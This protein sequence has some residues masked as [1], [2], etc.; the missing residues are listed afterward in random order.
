M[1]AMASWILGSIAVGYL[2]GAAGWFRSAR[3]AWE[4]ARGLMHQGRPADQ[5]RTLA[6][7]DALGSLLFFGLAVVSAAEAVEGRLSAADPFLVLGV[8][9]MAV[10]LRLAKRFQRLS[11]QVAD[12][13]DRAQRGADGTAQSSDLAELLGRRLSAVQASKIPGVAV[14][15]VYDP[16]EGVLGGDF[17][18]VSAVGCR[19]DIVVGDVTGHGFD[20]ALDAMRLKD[21]LLGL[22]DA[23][24]A[25]VV[26]VDTANTFVNRCWPVESYATVFV[27]TYENGAVRYAS[28]G[29]PPAVVVGDHAER[30][31][32]PTGPLLGVLQNP[33]FE[34]HGFVLEPG[35]ALVVFTDGLIE[36]YGPA[37][38]IDPDRIARLFR[39]G[40]LDAIHAAVRHASPAP[41]R[42]DIALL[43]IRRL[44]ADAFASLG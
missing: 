8:G 7:K 3:S 27:A 37:G 12:T 36:A 9:P 15:A 42:D 22:L 40:G 30:A 29:H 32:P 20:A 33:V 1:P 6:A 2:A 31:L 28:A 10:S 23:G 25:P 4:R 38:G 41:L 19:L 43:E 13:E 11:V 21:L 26:A 14:T 17:V 35:E 5:W 16:V 34:D 24:H 44:A 18:G 39:C